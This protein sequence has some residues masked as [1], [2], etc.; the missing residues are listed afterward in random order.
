MW[1][2]PGDLG[3]ILLMLMVGAFGSLGHYF[4]IA[5]HRR[6]PASLLAPFIYTQIAWAVILGYLVFDDVPNAWT[7]AGAALAVGSG[8]YILHR[9]RLRGPR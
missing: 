7:L 9:E 5:G 3:L 2:N 6:A 4:L 8:L 1:S